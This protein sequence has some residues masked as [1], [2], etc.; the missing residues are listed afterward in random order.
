[1]QGIDEQ[2]DFV[3]RDAQPGV[4]RQGGLYCTFHLAGLL[5][6]I[7]VERVQEIIRPQAMTPV[8]LAPPVVRGLINIRGQIVT[9]IDLAARLQ[10]ETQVAPC[11]AMTVVVQFR[12]R[13]VSLLVDR[14]GEVLACTSSSFERPPDTLSG[15]VRELIRGAF[16]LDSALMLLLDVDLLIDLPSGAG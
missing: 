12:R 13:T 2:S 11:D 3:P 14:I 6:G 7:E 5:F 9:A 10:L 8:P 1:V 15:S 4:E 16:K